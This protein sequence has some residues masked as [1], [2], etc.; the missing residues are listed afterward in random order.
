[1]N[2]SSVKM[3]VVVRKAGNNDL[4]RI[5]Q[6]YG[7]N[8]DSLLDIFSDARLLRKYTRLQNYAIAEIDDNFAG[9]AYYQIL[10]GKKPRWFDPHPSGKR[11]GHMIEL[12][13]K[14]AY[15]GHGIATRLLNF[16]FKDMRERG[17]Q[18][19]YIDVEK[20][21]R[22]AMNLY[23]KKFQFRAF[24]KTLHMKRTL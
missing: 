8:P 5:A 19:I 24:N 18:V 15:R 21:N 20:S 6:F 4:P 10:D 11:Y 9:F 1:M 17:V 12:H 14:K 23:T 13:V 16:A 7:P 22:V 3:S 2:E